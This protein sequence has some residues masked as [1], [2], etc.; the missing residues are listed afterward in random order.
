MNEQTT[1]EIYTIE[2]YGEQ[3]ILGVDIE[4]DGEPTFT[5]NSYTYQMKAISEKAINL[6]N[7]FYGRN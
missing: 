2:M 5:E 3:L 6:F 4:F 1:E 7:K